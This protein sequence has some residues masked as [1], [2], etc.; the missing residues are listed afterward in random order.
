MKLGKL[1]MTHYQATKLINFPK[2]VMKPYW[3]YAIN[4]EKQL[5]KKTEC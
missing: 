2:D 1:L 4:N 5:L 3:K